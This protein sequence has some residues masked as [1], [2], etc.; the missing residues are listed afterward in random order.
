[1]IVLEMA[2]HSERF[3]GIPESETEGWLKELGYEVATR[4]MNDVIYVNKG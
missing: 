4:I 1:M 2:G 3:Y